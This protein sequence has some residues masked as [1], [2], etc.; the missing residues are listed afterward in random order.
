[1]IPT[2]TRSLLKFPQ[3]DRDQNLLSATRA[4]FIKRVAIQR[5]IKL[6]QRVKR[7]FQFCIIFVRLFASR[8]RIDQLLVVLHTRKRF[9]P[10]EKLDRTTG[11]IIE[12]SVL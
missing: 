8:N 1:M 6:Q 3:P 11:A 10:N 9:V 4:T 7:A 12:K 5:E 2:Q